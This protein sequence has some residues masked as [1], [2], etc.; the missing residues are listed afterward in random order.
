MDISVKI[1]LYIIRFNL[2]NKI[3]LIHCSIRS[4]HVSIDIVEVPAPHIFEFQGILDINKG[5]QYVNKEKN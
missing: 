2:I 3:T 5:T 1:Q 4:Y